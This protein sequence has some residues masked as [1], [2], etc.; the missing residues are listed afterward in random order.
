MQEKCFEEVLKRFPEGNVTLSQLNLMTYVD[1]VL[2]ETKRL[3]PPVPIIAR[4]LGKDTK[5]EGRLL[6]KG[7]NVAI[8]LKT[9][10]TNPKYWKNP[11]TFNPDRF[12]RFES[13]EMDPFQFIPFSAGVRNCLGQKFA[14][15]Q[16]KIILVK[17]LSRFRILPGS[18]DPA[19]IANLVLRSENGISVRFEDR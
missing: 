14:L 11:E 5:F 2:K 7:L 9:L 12:S 10:H 13:K 16:E 19:E 15:L 18:E 8:H 6:P 17:V 1:T 4:K 3:H